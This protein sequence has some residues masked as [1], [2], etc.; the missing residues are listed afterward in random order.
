[1]SCAKRRF[2]QVVM[3]TFTEPRLVGGWKRI[4]AQEAA[5]V[6][7]PLQNLDSRWVG[8]LAR[9]RKVVANGWPRQAAI[10]GANQA[11]E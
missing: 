8:D 7:P 9:G 4:A 6:G 1:M 10:A 5:V 2:I 3:K 11:G